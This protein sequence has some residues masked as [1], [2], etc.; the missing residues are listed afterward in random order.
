MQVPGIPACIT[1]VGNPKYVFAKRII[2]YGEPISPE[3]LGLTPD[4]GRRELKDASNKIMDEIKKMRE[5]DLR[6]Y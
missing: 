4:G 1:V 3:E 2:H 5:Q 6:E